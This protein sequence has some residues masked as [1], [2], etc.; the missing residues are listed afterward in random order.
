MIKALAIHNSYIPKGLGT[1]DE[2]FQYVGF[3]KPDKVENVLKCSES[4]VTLMF[5]QEIFQGHNLKYPLAWSQSL[6]DSN[7][8]CRGKVRMTLVAGVPLDFEFGSEYIRASISASLQAKVTKD[9]KEH[10]LNKVHEDPD[11]NDLSKCYE[12]ERI[13]GGYKW[14][15]VKRYEADLK[16]I[17]AEDWRIK[18]SLLLRDGFELGSRPIKFALI[19]TLSDPDGIAPVYNEVIVGLRNKNV[20]TNPIQLRA[21]VQ[22]KVRV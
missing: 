12:K 16:R 22:E 15:P 8:K 18:V 4:E 14:K 1:S 9:G 13:K 7:G 17:I 6:K 21:Q 5:E 20:I 10:W 3:G 2:L 11:T 19:F